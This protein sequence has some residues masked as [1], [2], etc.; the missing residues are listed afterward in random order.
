M[1]PMLWIAGALAG[2]LALSGCKDDKGAEPTSGKTSAPAQAPAATPSTPPTGAP[3]DSAAIAS[4]PRVSVSLDELGLSIQ[5]P[6][7]TAPTPQRPDDRKRRAHL[8]TGERGFMININ[9]VDEY[10]IPSFDKAIEVY[11]DDQ[12]VEWYRKDATDTGWIT[13]KQVISSLHKG[14][15]FEVDVRTTIAGKAWECGVSAPNRGYADLA[16]EACQTL[17]AT[18]PATP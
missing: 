11:K 2:S 15:R 9:A 4:R 7:G 16:L 17:A 5:V 10:S 6:E 18:A 3:D 12:L 13:F 8:E 1:K 14:P